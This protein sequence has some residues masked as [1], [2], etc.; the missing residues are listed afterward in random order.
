ML[1]YCPIV[2]VVL[3]VLAFFRIS[4]LKLSLLTMLVSPLVLSRIPGLGHLVILP[5]HF[6]HF[7]F[8]CHCV[9]LAFL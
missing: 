7:S 1:E 9:I 2:V 4:R 8:P 3:F 5:L 6:V